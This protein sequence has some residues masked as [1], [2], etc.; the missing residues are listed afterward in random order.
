MVSASVLPSVVN[1]AVDSDTA[2]S[3]SLPRSRVT[4]SDRGVS[5][6]GLVVAPKHR[7][8]GVTLV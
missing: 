4:D 8:R 6:I 7:V 3:R 1:N 2:T 5:S